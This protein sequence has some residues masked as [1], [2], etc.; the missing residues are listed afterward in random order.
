MATGTRVRLRGSR[1]RRVRNN[2]P[3]TTGQSYMYPCRQPRNNYGS[4]WVLRHLRTPVVQDP[5]R[6]EYTHMRCLLL[7]R[8]RQR[9]PSINATQCERLPRLNSA[10]GFAKILRQRAPSGDLPRTPARATRNGIERAR[11]ANTQRRPCLPFGSERVRAYDLQQASQRQQHTTLETPRSPR[12]SCWEERSPQRSA[13]GSTVN[14]PRPSMQRLRP[15]SD[16][17]CD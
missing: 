9:M 13:Q 12:D 6:A 11:S 17:N 16:L 14:G 7:H 2:N 4:A 15:S 3:S 10:A 1:H 8:P 5:T